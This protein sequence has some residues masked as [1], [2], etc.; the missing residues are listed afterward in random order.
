MR[1]TLN[2]EAMEVGGGASI[3]SVLAQS[4]IPLESTAV[5]KNGEIVERGRLDEPVQEGDRIIVV[6]FV[7]GG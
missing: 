7:G 3:A 5:E 6:R 1:I 2:D 4:G